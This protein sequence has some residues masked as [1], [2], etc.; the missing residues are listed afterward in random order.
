MSP[1]GSLL[2]ALAVAGLLGG[3]WV[4]GWNTGRV[5]ANERWEARTL[6]LRTERTIRAAQIAGQAA[7]LAQMAADRDALAEQLEDAAHADDDASRP[8]FGP[9][10]MSRLNRR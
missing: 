10:S 2:A 6:A 4:H 7:M 5:G 3:I 8:A 1:V 9:D